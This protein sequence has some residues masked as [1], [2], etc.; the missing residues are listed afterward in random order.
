MSQEW[1]LVGF[2][3]SSKYRQHVVSRLHDSPSTP[4]EIAEDTGLA[5]SHVSRTLSALLDRSIVALTVPEDQHRN[6]VYELT[7]R[8][9]KLWER[10]QETGLNEPMTSD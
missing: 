2:V 10:I 6:R 9:Q 8:G 4:T 1:D 7:E 5:T 3:V